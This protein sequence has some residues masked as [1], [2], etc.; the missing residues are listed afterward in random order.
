MAD[1]GGEGRGVL[2]MFLINLPTR[3]LWKSNQVRKSLP[4]VSEGFRV[5]DVCCHD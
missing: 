3:L 1:L 4:R 2:V 5:G